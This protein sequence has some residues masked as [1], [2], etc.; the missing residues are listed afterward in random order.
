MMESDILHARII[1]ATMNTSVQELA[2]LYGVSRATISL[3]LRGI[4]YQE[5]GGPL[6]PGRKSRGKRSR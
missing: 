2:K 5:V 3:L 1:R 6:D 4:T